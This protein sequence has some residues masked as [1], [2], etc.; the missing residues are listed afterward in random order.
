ERGPRR[1]LDLLAVGVLVGGLLLSGSRS[2]FLILLLSLAV[3]IVGRGLPTRL[4]LA[5]LGLLA[6]ILIVLAIL[7][8]RSSP[9]TIGSRIAESFDPKLSIDYRVSQRPVLW[10]AA[11]SLFL[12]HPIEG[13]GIGSFSWRFPDLMREDSQRIAMRDNPGSAYIQALGE[14]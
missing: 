4:R 2:G 1:W 6:T 3:L 7:I 10:R 9:G 8:V 12:S 13:E 11:G 5:G 14:T